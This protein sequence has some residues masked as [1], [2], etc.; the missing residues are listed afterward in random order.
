MKGGLRD[1]EDRMRRSKYISTQNSRRKE[2][3]RT[4]KRQYLK[5]WLPRIFQKQWKNKYSK[6]HG[7]YTIFKTGQTYRPKENAP[8]YTVVKLKDKDE[9]QQG[10]TN[11]QDEQKTSQQQQ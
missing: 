5:K 10:T 9:E 2:P 3:E 4:K 1:M 11:R 8:K 6:T 7:T